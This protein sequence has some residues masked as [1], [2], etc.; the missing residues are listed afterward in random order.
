MNGPDHYRE[1]ERLIREHGDMQW[2]ECECV[3][4]VAEAQATNGE[5]PESVRQAAWARL[6]AMDG[7]RGAA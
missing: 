2:H 7:E 3:W 4:C 1:A 6:A 5:L